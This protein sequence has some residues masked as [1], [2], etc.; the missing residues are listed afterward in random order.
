MNILIIDDNSQI[1]ILLSKILASKG[2]TVTSS[3][4]F[5]DALNILHDRVFDVILVDAPMPGYENL[6]TITKLETEGILQSQKIILFTGLEV[7]QSIITEFQ[8][9]GLYSYLS[10]PLEV[11]RLLQELS[12]IPSI[13]NDKIIE[14]RISEEQTKKKMDDLRSTLSS[15]KLKLSP[16]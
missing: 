8:T 6:D 12:T 16:T 3:N 13:Q 10:K 5:D 4:S 7:P 14:K 15:L 2:H 1:T 11:Q 9:K